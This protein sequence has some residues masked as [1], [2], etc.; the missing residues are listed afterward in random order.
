MCNYCYGLTGG[1]TD[2]LNNKF[3][4]AFSFFL[5]DKVSSF[6][7]DRFTHVSRV[8]VIMAAPVL[9]AVYCYVFI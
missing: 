5:S 7:V 3:I 8:F 4:A 6:K 9:G 2:S 1:C